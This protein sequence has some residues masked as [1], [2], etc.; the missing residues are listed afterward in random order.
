MALAGMPVPSPCLWGADH[1]ERIPSCEAGGKGAARRKG[2]AA[3][4]SGS[5]GYEV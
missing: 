4:G 1:E 5:G 3:G 2:P